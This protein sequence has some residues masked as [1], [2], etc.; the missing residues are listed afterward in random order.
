MPI[1][2]A[3]RA[4]PGVRNLRSTTSRGSAEVSINFAWGED[5]V[6]ALLQIE[7]AI[8]QVM[9]NLPS[10]TTSNVRRM[11]PTVFPVL[12][13]SL[14]SDTR[15]LVELRDIALYQLRPLLSTVRGV[16]KIEVLGGAQR[17]YQVMVDP[18][19]LDSYGLALSDVAKALSAAN[20]IQA[21]GRL[22]DHYKLYLAMSD[23]S[24]GE[25]RADPQ[26]DPPLAVPRA[27]AA[28]RRSHGQRRDS[29]AVGAR[30]R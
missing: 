2:Q 5:M 3:V 18:A 20:V 4:V 19:R 28:R 11:D 26:H 13:Y 1:E 17:E 21:V 15:S 25:P 14:T 12:A 10:G 16:A 23:T 30:D 8:N 27:C 29:A 7:S 24:A 9:P 6:A 22:E